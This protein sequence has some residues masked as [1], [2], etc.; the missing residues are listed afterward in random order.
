MDIALLFAFAGTCFLVSASPGLCM[1]M[2]MSLGISVG[3]RRVLWMMLGEL[4]GVASVAAC[5]VLGV[6]ALLL[7]EPIIFTV[8]KYLGA[9][10]LFYT[11]WQAWHSEPAPMEQLASGKNRSRTSLITQGFVTAVSNPKAW[12]FWAALL[13][14]FINQS[15][16]LL[17]QMVV[18]LTVILIIEFICLQ[19][20]AHGGRA[21][22]EQLHRRGKARWLNR[23]SGSLMFVVG[24]WLAMS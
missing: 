6:A 4:A 19:F 17:P 18:M 2:S 3:T 9:A 16:P 23:I 24:V 14:P 5:A 20:Y 1:T 13:P 8:F 21:L 11:G 22:S 12:A 15:K 7:A 10:Y